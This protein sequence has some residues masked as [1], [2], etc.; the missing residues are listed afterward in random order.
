MTFDQIEADIGKKTMLSA[1]RTFAK[2]LSD[3]TFDEFLEHLALGFSINIE[4]YL[5]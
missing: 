5:E 4:N 2:K 1:L 3:F